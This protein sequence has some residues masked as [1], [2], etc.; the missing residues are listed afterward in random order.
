MATGYEKFEK[1]LDRLEKLLGHGEL[2]AF[3][4]H[5][6][7]LAYKPQCEAFAIQLLGGLKRLGIQLIAAALPSRY[8]VASLSFSLGFSKGSNRPEAE[9]R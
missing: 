7:H 5:Q 1:Q 4:S 2:E 8:E 9:L 6:V 3:P